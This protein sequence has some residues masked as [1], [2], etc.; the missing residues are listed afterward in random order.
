MGVRLIGCVLLLG[1]LWDLFTT[2][3]G[4]ADFFDLPTDPKTN[5]AQFIFAIVVTM[6]V[7]GFVIGTHLIWSL[8]SDDI[9]TLVLKAAWGV[10]ILIDLFTSWEGTKRFVFYGNDDD[11]ARGIGL[12]VV[13]ALI[14]SSSILLSKLLL[15]KDIRGKPFLF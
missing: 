11:A 15:A 4:V 8:K 12:G 2:F 9:P 5:P 3:R 1:G 10:C 13:T 14:V 6:V 7:F